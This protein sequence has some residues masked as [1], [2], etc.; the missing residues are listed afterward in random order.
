MGEFSTLY[1]K[2]DLSGNAIIS[3]H[4]EQIDPFQ[5]EMAVVWGRGEFVDDSQRGIEGET[6]HVE[7]HIQ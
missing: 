5:V 4:E 2:I 1:Q 6:D 7:N 3:D